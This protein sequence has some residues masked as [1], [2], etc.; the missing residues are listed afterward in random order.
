MEV[1]VVSNTRNTWSPVE[2]KIR[3]M[4]F[5]ESFVHVE[6]GHDKRYEEADSWS[7]KLFRTFFKIETGVGGLYCSDLNP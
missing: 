6:S 5:L 1:E 4:T 2:L 3:I 7:E